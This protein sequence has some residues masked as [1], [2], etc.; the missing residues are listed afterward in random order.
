MIW[1]W[2]CVIIGQSLLAFVVMLSNI[3]MQMHFS[4]VGENDHFIIRVRALYGL[5]RFHYVIPLLKFAGLKGIFIEHKHGM[6]KDIRPSSQDIIDMK[7][8]TQFYEQSNKL[9][10]HTE[11]LT[12]WTKQTMKHVSVT[13]LRWSTRIGLKD[14]PQTAILTGVIWGLKSSIVHLGA[15]NTMLRTQPKLHVFPLYNRQHF[16]TE[17][18]VVGHIRVWQATLAG[19]KLL[20]RIWRVKGGLATWKRAVFKPSSESPEPS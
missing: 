12:T 7:K 10:T 2:I 4:R 11:G 19:M 15:K 3:R 5:V 1:L 9:L 8:I 20:R 6:T 16:S 13:E 18:I 17:V 14:A